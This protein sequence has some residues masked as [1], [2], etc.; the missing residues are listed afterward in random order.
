M[1]VD[2]EPD[3]AAASPPERLDEIAAAI[4]AQARADGL[5]MAD[6]CRV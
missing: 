5:A 1:T 2:L 4:V 3:E 6:C